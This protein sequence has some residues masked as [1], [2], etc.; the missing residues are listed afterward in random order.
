ML[1]STLSA[2][3][4]AALATGALT[5]ASTAADAQSGPNVGRVPSEVKLSAKIAKPQPAPPRLACSAASAASR[6][7]PG[8]GNARQFEQ[9]CKR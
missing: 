1:K 6:A 7:A 2:V 5:A 4:F 9:S 8:N 3:V